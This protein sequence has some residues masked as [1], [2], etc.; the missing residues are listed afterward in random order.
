MKKLQKAVLSI[1]I[2]GLVVVLALPVI[3]TKAGLH[4]EYG[5]LSSD[6]NKPVGLPIVSFG[7]LRTP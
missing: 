2:L 6:R 1:I 4:P 7:L 5:T 3:M